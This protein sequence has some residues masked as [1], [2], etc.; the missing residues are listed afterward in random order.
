M[1]PQLLLLP[2]IT[3]MYPLSPFPLL[4]NTQLDRT[5]TIKWVRRPPPGRTVN[6]IGMLRI[7]NG[8]GPTTATEKARVRD[9]SSRARRPGG[10][11]Y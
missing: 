9:G 10:T 5:D 8:S 4:N 11:S 1:P 6:G 7:R 3:P 2:L